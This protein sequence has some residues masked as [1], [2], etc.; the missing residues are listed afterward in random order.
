[1]YLYTPL[2]PQTME[3]STDC[4]IA[5]KGKLSIEF[6]KHV[7]GRLFDSYSNRPFEI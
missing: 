6:L 5:N 3:A 4:H 7:K 1:M 2:D